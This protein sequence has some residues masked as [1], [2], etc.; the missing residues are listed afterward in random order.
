MSKK[1]GKQMKNLPSNY[2]KGMEELQNQLY[3]SDKAHQRVC[4]ENVE[5][6]KKI[7][8]LQKE[9]ERL[10]NVIEQSEHLPEY[11]LYYCKNCMQMKNHINGICQKCK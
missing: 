9:V 5:L 2:I 7:E 4:V 3:I 8:E 1:I 6:E 10:E 11:E